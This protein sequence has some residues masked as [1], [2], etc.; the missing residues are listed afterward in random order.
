MQNLIYN[1]LEEE[2]KST[3]PY[4]ISGNPEG[5]FSKYFQVTKI[6][7]NSQPLVRKTQTGFFQK[8][9]MAEGI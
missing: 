4:E 1:R 5:T 6:N 8:V 3:S 2:R 7:L 9:A